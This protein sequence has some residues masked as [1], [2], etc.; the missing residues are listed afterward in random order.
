[1]VDKA[2]ECKLGAGGL[3]PI[4]ET[5]IIAPMYEAPSTDIKDRVIDRAFAE[6]KIQK[7]Y[8]G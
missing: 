3:R 7:A 1:M 2:M 5:V 6:E 4:V 8:I